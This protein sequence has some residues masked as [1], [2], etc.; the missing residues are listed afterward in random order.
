MSISAS[1]LVIKQTRTSY[2][3]QT[4]EELR[5]ALENEIRAFQVDRELGQTMEISWNH[6]EFEVGGFRS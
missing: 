1:L 4:R 5:I 3:T 6:S 2:F